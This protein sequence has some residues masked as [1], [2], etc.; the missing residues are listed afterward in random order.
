[1]KNINSIFFSKYTRVL[2][3]GNECIVGN[4]AFDGRWIKMSHSLYKDLVQKSQNNISLL[5]E[6]EKK[7]I[8]A[9][10]EVGICIDNAE[11]DELQLYPSDITIEITTQ[12]NLAC[13]HC[14]YSFG[15]KK[16]RE[17]PIDMIK[18]I[19]KWAEDNKVK[20]IL[21]TGGEPFCRKDIV[22]V[23]KVIKQNFTGSLEII[24][25]GTLVTDEYIELIMRYI[26]ALHISLDGYDENS[27]SM[28]R[29]KG[30]YN[31]VIALINKLKMCGYERITLS[32][33]SVGDDNS[34][35]IKFK[36][37][38]E[39]L[40]IKPVIRQLN[41]KGRAE[42]NFAEDPMEL[43]IMHNLTEKGLTFKCLC[44]HQYRSIFI[45]TYGIVFSCAALREEE[46]GI[47]SFIVSEHKIHIDGLFAKPIVDKIA[48]CQNCNVR[49]FCADTCISRNNVIY[50]NNKKR[51]ERCHIKKNKL[52]KIVWHTDNDL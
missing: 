4:I 45:N 13:K 10:R 35:I 20:R 31:K 11:K 51:V 17:M 12:C 38:S 30:V 36:E 19:S 21:L 27:V 14:S 44:N 52:E 46:L 22:D 6:K 5:S 18:A 23:C 41:I 37:L 7:Y 15:G 3:N 16:Y 25:N 1:M 34:E 29:G 40:H 39:R 2:I 24:T 28:I 26:H 32:C 42:E 49:Y 48:P 33:V 50:S 9:F 43:R 8:N 47:G